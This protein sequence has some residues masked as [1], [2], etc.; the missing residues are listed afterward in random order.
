MRKINSYARIYQ[1]KIKMKKK[2]EKKEE[3]N[4]KDKKEDEDINLNYELPIIISPNN[5]QETFNGINFENLPDWEYNIK[6]INNNDNYN[7]NCND[8][9]IIN[10]Q[11]FE[12]EKCMQKDKISDIIFEKNEE[13]S[14]KKNNNSNYDNNNKFYDKPIKEN[15]EYLLFN[16]FS[17]KPF[18]ELSNPSNQNT[19][20]KPSENYQIENIKNNNYEENINYEKNIKSNNTK[21][22]IYLNSKDINFKNNYDNKLNENDMFNDIKF[23]EENC[24]KNHL[25]ENNINSKSEIEKEIIKEKILPKNLNESDL[26]S[27]SLSNNDTFNIT[28]IQMNILNKEANQLYKKYIKNNSNLIFTIKHPHLNK[29]NINNLKDKKKI[30]EPLINRQKEILKNNL[31]KNKYKMK[32]YNSNNIKSIDFSN[33]SKGDFITQIPIYNN[34]T[35]NIKVNLFS[36]ENSLYN[37]F[38][39][40]SIQNSYNKNLPNINNSINKNKIKYKKLI[41][42]P[43]SIKEYKENCKNY[44]YR[45]PS[46]LGN[47]IGSPQW[48]KQH[49][50]LE[51][52]IEYSKSVKKIMKKNKS[53]INISRT[54]I[55]KSEEIN[56]VKNKNDEF[57]DSLEIDNKIS[58]ENQN[59]KVKSKLNLLKLPS[60]P[61]HPI[62]KKLNEKNNEKELNKILSENRELNILLF[63]HNLY[64]I[65]V[66]K[67]KQS[68]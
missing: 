23:E 61:K 32:K 21:E 8:K 31:N 16:K 44:N 50:Q 25:N 13:I 37:S 68:L 49:E 57:N 35:K 6:E 39:N 40:I 66:E 43:Y 15:N 58:T 41:Y 24:N 64:N 53:K 26:I 14:E 10:D 56:N 34:S 45:F 52:K 46:S 22:N 2:L 62:K 7:M 11:N 38:N 54:N 19:F 17:Q 36:N 1:E 47:N 63:N 59:C 30:L 12:E 42:K 60:I 3:G 33:N 27:C 18:K 5:D 55:N 28:N 51:K 9:D 67:I 4:E 29:R 48:I 65:E 20:Q